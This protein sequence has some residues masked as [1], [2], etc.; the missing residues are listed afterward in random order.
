LPAKPAL[1]GAIAELVSLRRFLG[2]Y[3]YSS[4]TPQP[5]GVPGPTT[6]A[7]YFTHEKFEWG[8]I[9]L[10]RSIKALTRASVHNIEWKP[11]LHSLEITTRKIDGRPQFTVYSAGFTPETPPVFLLEAL[12]E[13]HALRLLALRRVQYKSEAEQIRAIQR[14][15]RSAAIRTATNVVL[16]ALFG[17]AATAFAALAILPP[18][19]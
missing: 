2:F 13:L 17:F 12:E 15:E 10:A 4:S 8:G 1:I 16:V 3:P 18:L 11:S 5:P 9:P 19:P 14:R 6:L 7:Y